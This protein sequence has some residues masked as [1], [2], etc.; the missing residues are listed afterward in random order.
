MK[1]KIISIC[2][3]VAVLMASFVGCTKT[4]GTG[5][6]K[7]KPALEGDLSAI[8]EKIYEKESVDLRVEN[9]EIDLNDENSPKYYMGLEDASKIKEAAVSEAMIGSQAYSLV[10]ARVKNAT[11]AEAVAKSMLEGIDQRKWI[12]VEADDLQIVTYNDV[13]LLV[14]VESA[15]EDVVTSQ[16]LVDAFREIVGADFD[17]KLSK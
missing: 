11:D 5:G 4:D 3:L 6:S 14:M 17:L 13:V 1:K 16:K 15:M 12:C 10:L 9:K 8:I 2:M 7:D